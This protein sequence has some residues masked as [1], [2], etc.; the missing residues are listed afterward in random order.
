MTSYKVKVKTSAVRGAGTDA[1]VFINL[2]GENGNSGDL[3]LKN[4]E[5]NKSPFD[6]DQLDEFTISDI[7]SVGELSKLRVWHDNKGT[8]L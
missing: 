7:L 5:T 1:N 4:S 2:F 3:H 6:N 8:P